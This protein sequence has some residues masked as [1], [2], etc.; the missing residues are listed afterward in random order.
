MAARQYYYAAATAEASTT[1]TA[2]TA[3]AT[4]T[5]TPD[6][7]SDYVIMWSC[8]SKG[9]GTTVDTN[10]KLLQGTTATL[11][12]V[13]WESPDT[14]T[15]RALGGVAVATFATAT[16]S[17]S[18]NI[19][20]GNETTTATGSQ[21]KETHLIAV[22]LATSDA[23]MFSTATARSTTATTYQ[24]AATLSFTPSATGDYL[25]IGSA[26][27]SSPIIVGAAPSIL[28]NVA[29]TGT[30]YGYSK[31]SPKDTSNFYS[32]VTAQQLPLT[33]S[34]W[35]V[36]IQLAA[37]TAT[38]GISEAR[39][40]AIVS[41]R[42]DGGFESHYFAEARPTVTVT[43]TA[44]GAYSKS[45]TLDFAPTAT[46]QF[47]A[48]FG[49]H[50]RTNSVA[51]DVENAFDGTNIGRVDA[52]VELNVATAGVF[53]FGLKRW[54]ATSTAT[55]TWNVLHGVETTATGAFIEKSEAFI[56]LLQLDAG[57]AGGASTFPVSATT[58]VKFYAVTV[59]QGGLVQT[60]Q[61]IYRASLSKQAAL[62]NSAT[63]KWS[64][65]AEALK[66]LNVIVD[67]TVK[68]S[69]A[70]VRQGQ[71]LLSSLVDWAGTQTGQIGKLL[72]GTVK[73]SA[74]TVRSA[75]LNF[76]ALYRWSATA[77][78]LKVFQLALDATV[79]FSATVA[80]ETA[81]SAA[82]LYR[83]GAAAVATFISGGGAVIIQLTLDA[84]Y[85]FVAVSDDFFRAFVK[86]FFGHAGLGMLF[87][88]R[89]PNRMQRGRR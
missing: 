1:A 18:F 30:D 27:R 83:W 81:L 37:S 59:R 19:T 70:T 14:T 68:F 4:L 26:A 71:L 24:T 45:A 22:K 31:L 46:A 8:L 15:Y 58:N 84:T 17:H 75:A 12:S 5:F 16:G 69:A 47:M 51:I 60:P 10:V 65:T 89:R 11:N 42:L 7:N 32:W 9:P 74:T 28:L 49:G 61:V 50:T 57:S 63:Y 80:R 25:I 85:K 73:F 33:A 21:I 35:D 36:A 79:R 23:W 44:T 64:A 52:N 66:V 38:G 56:T 82:A 62:S 88:R 3:V 41:M 34:Q 87:R 13:N 72:S 39:D 78:V 54:D 67:A 29:G 77:A 86:A 6:D 55:R 2:D 48:L 43:A 53:F 40:F 76:S 20:H